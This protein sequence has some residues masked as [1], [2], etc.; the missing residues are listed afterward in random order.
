M[1]RDLNVL[2]EWASRLTFDSLPAEVVERAQWVLR[3]TVAATV[4]G[5]QE[6]EVLALADFAAHEHP[7]PVT[8]PGHGGKTEAEWASL[9]LG[10]AGTT[11]EM[12]EGHAYARGHAAVHAAGP[13]LALAE[14]HGAPGRDAIAAFVAGYEVAA[15][16]GIATRLRPPVHP[17]G[18][19]GVLGAATIAAWFKGMDAV[20][21]AGV[22]E[23][24]ASYA[25]AP[26]FAAAFQGANV[27]NT[28]AGVVNRNG[29]Q[30]A[31]LY[32]LGFRGE[33]SGLQTVF[34]EIL[35]Q[36]FDVTALT[37]GLGERYEIMRGYFKPYSA[38]RYT[39]GAVDAI[40]ALKADQSLEPAVIES[41]DVATYDIAAQ[42]SD[43]APE[44]PLAGRFS[45]PYVVAACLATGGAGPEIFQPDVMGNPTIRDLAHSVVITEE[46][47]F[48][49]MTPAQR[50]AR[51]TVHLKDGRDLEKT[52]F[53][54]KGDPDQPMTETELEA[55]FM[56]LVSGALGSAHAREAWNQLGQLSTLSSLNELIDLLIPD[57]EQH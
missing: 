53:S 39:H 25:I 32:A 34:G 4:A 16:V 3:D 47:A 17:F 52:V 43:S 26:S 12:D 11:L 20:D 46:P 8:L 9:V 42:L 56:G 15:R 7:G 5:M 6:P 55:K 40:L 10:T 27:R 18:A 23:L 38:C 2:A 28:F 24:A 21:M 57:T 41:V 49:A 48:T 31:E 30:A 29:L 44:T 45:M 35:G 37:D 50:P 14:L 19:W 1:G 51:V 13:A 33:R 54:S 22:L 36:S